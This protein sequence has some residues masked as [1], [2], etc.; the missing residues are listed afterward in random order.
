MAHL[1]LER[2]REPVGKHG[3][4]WGALV[5]LI[6][7]L[8]S[9][10][11]CLAAILVLPHGLYSLHGVLREGLRERWSELALSSVEGVYLVANVGLLA[12]NIERLGVCSLKHALSHHKFK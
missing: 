1:V 7:E 12:R 3:V 2:I 11:Q 9:C 10:Q 5:Y 4:R 8:L 6:C